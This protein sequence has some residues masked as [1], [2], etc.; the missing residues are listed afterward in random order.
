MQTFRYFAELQYDGTDYKGWQIQP[1]GIT[2]QA[3]LEKALSLILQEKISVIGAGR[4]DTGV[5]ARYFVMHFDTTHDL[6]ETDCEQL[7][8]KLN[9]FLPESISFQNINKVNPD[10]HARF[11]AISRTYKYYISRKKNPFLEKYSWFVYGDINIE[12]MNIASNA[13]KLHD[14]FTSFSKLHTQTKTNLCKISH[15]EWTQQG[16]MLIFTIT[17]DRFLRNMVRAIVGTLIDLGR[18]HLTLEE[19]NEAILLKNRQETGQSA[20]AR[21]LFLE[22]ITYPKSISLKSTPN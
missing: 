17:A 20:P 2:V 7:C 13:L 14:D 11:D 21:G 22:D 4:T 16:D 3:E 10:A 12:L 9:R 1:N 19:F 8:Y 5:H 6:N 15:A 18:G